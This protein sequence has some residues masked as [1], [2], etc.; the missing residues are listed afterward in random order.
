[1]SGARATGG[2]DAREAELGAPADVECLKLTSWFGE[3][4]RSEG[5]LVADALLD[6]YGRQRIQSSVVLRGAQGFGAKHRLRSDRLLTLSEDLPVV[7]IAL[8][9]RERIE[10]L[11]E[12]VREIQHRGLLTVERAR[13]LVRSET[14]DR[15]PAPL[16]RSETE[17]HGPAP[18]VGRRTED[19]GPAPLVGSQTE[20]GGPARD[21]NARASKLTIYLDRHDRVGGRPAFV[22]A[23]ELLHRE[24][25]A[26][27][28]ALLGVD[29]TRHGHRRRARFFARNARVPMMIVAV[30]PAER[31][32]GVLPELERT[33]KHPLLTLE[34][35]RV[36][37]RDGRLIES[38]HEGKAVDEHGGELWQKLT[39]V[40]SEAARHEGRAVHLEL[41]RRLRRARAAGATSLRGM[42]GFH[43][44]HAPHGDRVL[45]LR[46]HVPV[47]T[48]L[49]D[50]Q[51]R[52]E[53]LF[54]IVDELTREHGLVT[55]EL[56]CSI[57]LAGA[58]ASEH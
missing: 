4:D 26:G 2:E 22:A 31:I 32:A 33:L 40:T 20:D 25:V 45:S 35:V 3:R 7:A 46:R 42:W 54:P 16:V 30:G 52:M 8:D 57:G 12:S 11:L 43:G 56:A 58:G 10:E 27:A 6:L 19:R 13:M 37:K 47:F 21:G 9:A 18:L 34:H 53:A 36:C 41:V 55:S 39:V 50:R 17:D 44:A 23:C 15:G 5:Q 14:E 51:E 24:G 38:P 1:V 48:I 28:S 29:G 49:F